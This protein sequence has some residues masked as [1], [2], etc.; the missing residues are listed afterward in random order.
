MSVCSASDLLDL[1]YLLNDLA[2]VE[3]EGHL[4]RLRPL[5]KLLVDRKAALLQSRVVGLWHK[6]H[7]AQQ[8]PGVMM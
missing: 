6:R 5:L 3:L 4:H 2:V 7:T 8:V 1:T